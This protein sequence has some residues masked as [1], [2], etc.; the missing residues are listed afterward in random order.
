M[1]D[2]SLPVCHDECLQMLIGIIDSG[3]DL[4]SLIPVSA[5]Q[6]LLKLAWKC[7]FPTYQSCLTIL[8]SRFKQRALLV[9]EIWHAAGDESTDFPRVEMPTHNSSL[10]CP[11]L[12][13][14]RVTWAFL[15]A[16]VE[17]AFDLK[18][19]IQEATNLADAV[20]AG[21][22]GSLQGLMKESFSGLKISGI[23][24]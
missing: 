20:G 10:S 16:R 23:T 13:D 9:H 12:T 5:L 2:R 15:D 11:S 17:D 21:V 3:E 6:N 7:K 18:K 19:T 8:A 1:S 4:R 14:F 24:I 22:G